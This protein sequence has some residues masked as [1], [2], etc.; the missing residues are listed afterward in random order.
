[1]D[2]IQ[3]INNINETIGSYIFGKWLTNLG[4]NVEEHQQVKVSYY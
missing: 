2:V 1:M 3:I 4:I